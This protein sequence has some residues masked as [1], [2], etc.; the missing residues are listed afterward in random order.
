VCRVGREKLD[1]SF[2]LFHALSQFHVKG[3]RHR[4]L[5]SEGRIE[6][7]Q[8]GRL[9]VMCGGATSVALHLLSELGERARRVLMLK[10]G[11][12]SGHVLF[13]YYAR[14][15]EKWI[16]VDIHNHALLEMEGCLIGLVELM[17]AVRCGGLGMHDK[18]TRYV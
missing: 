5:S 1:D 13:E 18:R 11:R 2:R 3:L 8:G 4:E 9:S 15:L 17:A 16:L 10:V 12:S 14:D 6:V 7:A